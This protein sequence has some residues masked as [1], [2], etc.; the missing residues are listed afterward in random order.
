MIKSERQ[1]EGDDP[2]ERLGA[3]QPLHLIVGVDRLS[4]CDHDTYAQF[5]LWI[6]RTL[7]SG[8]TDC[9]AA[10]C[11]SIAHWNDQAASE[12]PHLL[13]P[14][15]CG[16]FLPIDV[17]PGPMLGSALGLLSDLHRLKGVASEI[18][19][20]FIPLVEA[21]MEMAELSIATNAPLEIR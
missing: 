21:L 19:A 6:A 7:T 16:T 1:Q 17:E 10:G 8:T 18:P 14:C 20:E 2:A 5:K 3:S 11:V 4:P 9:Y 13:N 12:Y 15:E